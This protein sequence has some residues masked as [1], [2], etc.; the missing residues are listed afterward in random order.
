MIAV[1]VAVSRCAFKG[2]EVEKMRK[3]E[4]KREDKYNILEEGDAR[5][6][7]RITSNTLGARTLGEDAIGN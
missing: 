2:Q 4:R 7:E 1:F 3:G 6:D 5:E